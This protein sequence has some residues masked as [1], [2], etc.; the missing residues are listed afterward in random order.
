MCIKEKRI[1]LSDVCGY[2]NELEDDDDKIALIDFPA[3]I[4]DGNDTAIQTAERE[5]LEETGFQLINP[6]AT[7]LCFNS[8]G[9]TDESCIIVYGD[10][11]RV[12][13]Q[14]LQDNEEIEVIM[15]KDY[16]QLE[17]EY[18]GKNP[19]GAKLIQHFI[20]LFLNNK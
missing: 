3:G 17:R 15:I 11:V 18:L 9:M 10:A 7:P 14:D 6:I 16:A 19:I 13:E 5:L 20:T 1:V 2:K 8:A 12:G 4:I